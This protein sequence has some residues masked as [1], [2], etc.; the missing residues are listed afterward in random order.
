MEQ[1]RLRSCAAKRAACAACA[2]LL[3]VRP[4]PRREIF[5]H[6]EPLVGEQALVD[7]AYVGK[8]PVP[9]GE[10]ALWLFVMVL[11]YS[12][13]LWAEFVMDLRC[14]TQKLAKTR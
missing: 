6:T 11:S 1:R 5:L 3:K 12:R 8:L 4:R 13:A 2:A 10:R 9:G 14:V 7:W